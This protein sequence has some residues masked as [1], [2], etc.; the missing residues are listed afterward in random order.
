M[1]VWKVI[2]TQ[3]YF[4]QEGVIQTTVVDISSLVVDGNSNW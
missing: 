2:L 1:N 4:S 3:L